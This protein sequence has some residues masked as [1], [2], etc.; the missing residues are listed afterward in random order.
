MTSFYT[1]NM[2]FLTKIAHISERNQ[3]LA[4]T[5]PKNYFYDFRWLPSSYSSQ[6][7][8]VWYTK[9]LSTTNG[10]DSMAAQSRRPKNGSHLISSHSGIIEFGQVKYDKFA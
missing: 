4:Q 5:V 10:S 3:F 9:H 7:K 2:D 1:K 6:N 8:W